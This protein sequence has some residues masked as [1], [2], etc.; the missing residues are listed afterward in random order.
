MRRD[1]LFH[2]FFLATFLILLYQFA[3][4][5]NPFLTPILGAIVLLILAYPLH[6]WL[7][8][9][10]KHRSPGFSAFL[11][12]LIVTILI[13][14]PFLAICWLFFNESLSMGPV[15]QQWAAALHNW[16]AGAAL[17]SLPWFRFVQSRLLH[18]FGIENIDFQSA[19]LRFLSDV[20]SI[21]STTGQTI[22]K[23]AIIS[24]GNILIMV[25]TLF[26]LF[27]DGEG[28]LVQIKRLIPMRAEHK[29][30]LVQRLKVTVTEIVRGSVVTSAIQSVCAMIGYLIMD[31]PAAFTLGVLTG[32]A[33]FIPVIGS[34][35]IW[36]PLGIVLILQ[37]AMLKG[38]LILVWGLLVI[39][40]LDNVL[41]TWLIGRKTKLPI[42]FLF[43]SII[44]GAEVYGVKGLLIG[45][46]LVAILPVFFDIYREQYLRKNTPEA[47]E[48]LEDVP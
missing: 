46:L 3:L 26:F 27:K 16:H 34:A 13:V 43:F 29:D 17:I 39:S 30:L 18:V 32:I 15:L 4:I 28:I 23:N 36:A 37:G 42:L 2:Y 7:K 6:H 48:V 9:V 20:F 40:M 35:L 14:G 45:P 8:R 10:L 31:V 44:G 5:L 21:V 25:F 19:V 47:V 1:S 24:A 33:S 12:T 22:A 11:S 41:R 38:I